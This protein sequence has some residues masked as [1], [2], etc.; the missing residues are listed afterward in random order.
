LLNG[1][2]GGSA[3]GKKAEAPKQNETKLTNADKEIEQGSAPQDGK[4]EL[5]VQ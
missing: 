5:K 1:R 3:G 2:F 4:E